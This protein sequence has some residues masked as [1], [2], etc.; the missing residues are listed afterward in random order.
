MNHQDSMPSSTASVPEAMPK[1]KIA[2]DEHYSFLMDTL[3]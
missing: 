2:L 1:A 3:D